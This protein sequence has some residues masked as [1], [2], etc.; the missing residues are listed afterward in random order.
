MLG[1]K[2]AY[3]NID[4]KRGDAKFGDKDDS[5]ELAHAS[6]SVKIKK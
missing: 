6:V 3:I 2:N 1:I 4:Y 5:I